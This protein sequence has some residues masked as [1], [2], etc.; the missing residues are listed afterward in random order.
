MQYFRGE[1]MEPDKH[2]AIDIAGG[3]RRTPA[4]HIQ[5]IAKTKDFSL[6]RPPPLE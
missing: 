6:R 3:D 5:L 2:S 1:A 4:L